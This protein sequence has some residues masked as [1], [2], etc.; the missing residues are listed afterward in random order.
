MNDLVHLGRLVTLQ[1]TWMLKS[2]DTLIKLLL[3]IKLL[4]RDQQLSQFFGTKE[5]VSTHTLFLVHRNGCRYATI[6]LFSVTSFQ[7]L[8][9]EMYCI[10]NIGTQK[11]AYST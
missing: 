9:N 8:T 7:I 5:S 2:L 3:L 11:L 4:S 6:L 1:L 10:K